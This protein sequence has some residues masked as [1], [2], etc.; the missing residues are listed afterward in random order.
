MK[1]GIVGVGFMGSTHAAG[2]AE[3]GAHI[4]GFVAET[5]DEA[6]PLAEQYGVKIYP[7]LAACSTRWM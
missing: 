6:H 2:W 5:A 3:T 4:A 1:V 7:D